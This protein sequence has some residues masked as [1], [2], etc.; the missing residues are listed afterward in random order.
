MKIQVLK[1]AKT[2]ISWLIEIVNCLDLRLTSL[3]FFLDVELKIKA[4]KTPYI[5]KEPLS[6]P[7]KKVE[8][9]KAEKKAVDI[10]QQ[11][12]DLYRGSSYE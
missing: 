10:R 4:G 11:L 12:E 6:K 8:L 9:P 5:K 7:P 1:W 3:W 2:A